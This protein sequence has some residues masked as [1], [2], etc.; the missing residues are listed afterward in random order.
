MGPVGGRGS[1]ALRPHSIWQT[2]RSCQMPSRNRPE[3]RRAWAVSTVSSL[4]SL[5][6]RLA[7]GSRAYSV[8]HSALQ[9]GE[10]FCLCDRP[11]IRARPSV[12]ASGV[13][14]TCGDRHCPALSSRLTQPE[15]FPGPCDP[16]EDLQW[17]A[18]ATLEQWPSCCISTEPPNCLILKHFQL[19][20]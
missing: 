15:K 5:T 3:A 20:Y 12:Y 4:K 10:G 7:H 6:L 17:R 14:I 19:F 16:H 8:F 13:V 2:R 18:G 11:R 1:G 9:F